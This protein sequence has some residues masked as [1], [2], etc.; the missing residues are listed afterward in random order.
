MSEFINKRLQSLANLFFDLD[1]QRENL[2]YKLDELNDKIL[3]IKS[4]IQFS[5][6]YPNERLLYDLNELI[7]E[8]S[9]MDISVYTNDQFEKAYPEEA[10]E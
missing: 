6:G 10:V 4:S 7:L 9:P 5:T 3:E 2:L 8:I 1:C